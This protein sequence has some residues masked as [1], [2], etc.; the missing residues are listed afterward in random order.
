MAFEDGM[1]CFFFAMRK[2][3]QKTIANC[4]FNVQTHWFWIDANLSVQFCDKNSMQAKLMVPSNDIT[5]CNWSYYQ[6]YTIFR[7]GIEIINE[8]MR[9]IVMLVS[10]LST[11]EPINKNKPLAIIRKM[12][13][14]QTIS[15][16]ALNW[17]QLNEL[18]QISIYST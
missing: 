3:A 10:I 9:I 13:F 4:L 2:D 14:F 11:D 6:N 8:I 17:K 12:F 16:S 7:A 18:S 1:Q 5:R 15:T